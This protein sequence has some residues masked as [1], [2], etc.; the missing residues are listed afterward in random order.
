LCNKFLAKAARSGFYPVTFSALIKRTNSWSYVMDKREPAA[1]QS[2]HGVL[3][4]IRRTP[5]H[6][7]RRCQQIAVAIFLD[8]FRNAGLTPVQFAALSMIAQ[9]PGLDQ[10]RLVALIAVDRSTIGTIL[11]S[12]EK[13]DLVKRITPQH[14]QRV[15]QLFIQPKGEDLLRTTPQLAERAQNRMMAPLTVAEQET[16]MRLL[17]QLVDGNNEFSRVPQ[18]ANTPEANGDSRMIG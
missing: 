6:L 16:F 5:G 12:M 7:I 13:R 9:H 4:D 14:N 1:I 18:C 3:R 8:E 11:L 15:K 10:S 17:G 2:T